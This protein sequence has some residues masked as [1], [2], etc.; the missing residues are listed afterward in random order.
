MARYF[1][2]GT[3]DAAQVADLHGREIHH[4]AELR[5]A[6]LE[7][8]SAIRAF[9]G[10]EHQP[11]EWSLEVRLGETNRVAAIPFD[12]IDALEGSLVA[13]ESIMPLAA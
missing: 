5:A 10:E 7:A 1:F 3:S 9:V 8:V 6:I 13:D 12:E 11:A 2:D 4:K